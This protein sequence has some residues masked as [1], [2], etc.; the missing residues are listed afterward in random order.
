MRTNSKIKGCTD[1]RMYRDRAVHR[2]KVSGIVENQR[3]EV[4]EK[5]LGDNIF[6]RQ[7]YSVGLS[8]KIGLCVVIA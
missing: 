7:K 2:L 5:I 4:H 6:T 8:W 3:N 1:V